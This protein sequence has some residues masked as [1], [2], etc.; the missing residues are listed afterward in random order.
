[1]KG[2]VTRSLST[3]KLQGSDLGDDVRGLCAPGPLNGAP[4]SQPHIFN[5]SVLSYT[6][7]YRSRM[8]FWLQGQWSV[9]KP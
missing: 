3:E 4:F 1:M 6:C 2:E 8:I 7:C 5:R 9:G